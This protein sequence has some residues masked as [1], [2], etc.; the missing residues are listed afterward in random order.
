MSTLPGLARV[1]R[2]GSVRETDTAM[3]RHI[4]DGIVPRITIGIEPGN[5]K[6]RLSADGVEKA[7]R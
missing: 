7:A 4:I 3:V 5:V 2:Y 6:A 1:M